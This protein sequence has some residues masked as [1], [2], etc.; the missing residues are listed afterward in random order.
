MGVNFCEHERL[1]ICLLSDPDSGNV[2]STAVLGKSAIVVNQKLFSLS[3]PRGPMSPDPPHPN[4]FS[5]H[6]N[7]DTNSIYR[8][9]YLLNG[10]HRLKLD[11]GIS[12]SSVSPARSNPERHCRSNPS[13]SVFRKNGQMA[14]SFRNSGDS[15]EFIY[16]FEFIEVRVKGQYLDYFVFYHKIDGCPVCHGEF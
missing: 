2:R 15:G 11:S 13:H 14:I 7:G 4:N 9:N 6:S 1:H 5:C 12:P 3:S 10:R 16:G 8:K